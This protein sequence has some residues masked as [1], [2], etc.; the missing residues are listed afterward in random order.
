[1]RPQTLKQRSNEKRWKEE[2]ERDEETKK[3]VYA[4][5]CIELACPSRYMQVI[6]TISTFL[7]LDVSSKFPDTK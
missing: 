4:T 2:N 5:K 3:A 1:M 6:V 7:D